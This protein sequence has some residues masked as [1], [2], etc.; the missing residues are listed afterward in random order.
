MSTLAERFEQAWKAS[1]LEKADVERRVSGDPGGHL[2]HV[3]AG[4]R[5]KLSH[6]MLVR[7]AEAFSVR[8]EW[9]A[10]G[11]GPMRADGL[12]PFPL[13]STERPYRFSSW[14][15]ARPIV[16]RRHSDMPPED[17]AA[18]LDSLDQHTF[19]ADEDP[20]GGE[21]AWW[22][23]ESDRRRALFRVVAGGEPA[24]DDP[25]PMTEEEQA[26]LAPAPPSESAIRKKPGAAARRAR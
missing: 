4:R 14:A 9:L 10:T 22:L 5:T 25:H 7:Y 21:I 15:G 1:G 13:R 17:L 23:Q 16:A 18:L 12:P 3:L 2:S 11:D 8:P 24:P 26:A 20:S 19:H 6:H